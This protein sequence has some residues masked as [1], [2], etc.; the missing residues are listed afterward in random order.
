[1]GHL[2]WV[3]LTSS[4]SLL[5]NK[6]NYIVGC[7]IQKRFFDTLWIRKLDYMWHAHLPPKDQSRYVCL[8]PTVVLVLMHI[9]LI[10]LYYIFFSILIYLYTKEKSL[11]Q[12]IQN[13]STSSQSLVFFRSIGLNHNSTKLIYKWK[14][15]A[16]NIMLHDSYLKIQNISKHLR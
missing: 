11:L 3:C 8:P 5:D 9:A 16:M 1:M 4:R 15:N 10:V 14:N 7:V 13:V 12:Y 2:I 6:P